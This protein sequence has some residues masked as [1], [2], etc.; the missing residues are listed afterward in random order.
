MHPS[1][2][3]IKGGIHMIFKPKIKSLLKMA[4]FYNPTLILHGGN[5]PDRCSCCTDDDAVASA[6]ERS[7]EAVTALHPRHTAPLPRKGV[8]GLV[9]P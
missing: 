6:D 9:L 8:L 7:I 4:H 1:D 5:L 3:S 2:A